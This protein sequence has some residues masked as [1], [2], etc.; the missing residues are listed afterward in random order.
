MT[1]TD[2]TF[3]G[4]VK[5]QA[6]VNVTALCINKQILLSS[7]L[8]IFTT[9]MNLLAKPILFLAFLMLLLQCK[10]RQDKGLVQYFK[11]YD[12]FSRKGIGPVPKDSLMQPYFEVYDLSDTTIA[13]NLYDSIN[14]QYIIPKGEQ[15][16]FCRPGFTATVRYSYTKVLSDRFIEY[17]YYET[18]PP[19]FAAAA[20]ETGMRPVSHVIP[21]F[22]HVTF[23]NKDSVLT[24]LAECFLPPVIHDI[25]LLIFNREIIQY[26]APP[27]A[28]PLNYDCPYCGI[29]Y[30]DSAGQTKM[31]FTYRYA[32]QGLSRE[33]PGKGTL[34][35]DRRFK[36]WRANYP[37]TAS[38][39]VNR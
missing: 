32:G 28:S 38:A 20:A 3:R 4:T 36:Y 6:Q 19:E 14:Q 35:L 12:I 16:L 2:D 11:D 31:F 17:D 10:P 18:D 1:A 21:V 30:T 39:F 29:H 34:H 15:V 9:R 33:N 25:N 8:P 24:L 7:Q 27:F 22:A 5:I 37:V 23:R 13:V 26:S